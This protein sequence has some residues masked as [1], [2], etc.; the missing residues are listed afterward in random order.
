M[1]YINDE[2]LLKIAKPLV[3]SGYGDYLIKLVKEDF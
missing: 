2:Q 1:G 3:K